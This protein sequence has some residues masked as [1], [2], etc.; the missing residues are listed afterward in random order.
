[1]FISNWKEKHTKILFTQQE[2][3]YKDYQ[4]LYIADDGNHFPRFRS[5]DLNQEYMK[6]DK[7]IHVIC[8][9]HCQTEF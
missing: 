1:M 3:L 7:G 6:N 5:T 4:N 2:A 8:F 9:R